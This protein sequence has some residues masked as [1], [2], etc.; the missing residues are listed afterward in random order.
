MYELTSDGRDLLEAWSMALEQNRTIL[1][2][3]L[4]RYGELGAQPARRKGTALSFS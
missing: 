2:R 4:E 3:F 1:T